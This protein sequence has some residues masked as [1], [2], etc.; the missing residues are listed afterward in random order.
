P[1]RGKHRGSCISRRLI[2]G[3]APQI[4]PCVHETVGGGPSRNRTGV[5]G[6][7]VLCVTTP[8]SG[9]GEAAPWRERPRPASPLADHM[10]RFDEWRLARLAAVD[11]SQLD[12][13]VYYWHIT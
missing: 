11:K 13:K 2:F 3:P 10:D 6:F 7:A 5:Q 1:R 9:R 12:L 4:Q 8:P